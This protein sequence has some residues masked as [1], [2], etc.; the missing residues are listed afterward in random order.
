MRR[1]PA[2]PRAKRA[3]LP[4]PEP[5][6][7]RLCLT[8]HFQF[9]YS[10]D[11]LG[12]FD[13]PARRESLERAGDTLTSLLADSLSP[14][15][16]GG[17]N[18]W[19]ADFDDPATGLPTTAVNLSIP[20][21]T[22]L[23]YA[24]GR[25][26]DGSTLGIGATGGFSSF[27]TVAWNNTVKG[28]GHDAALTS[29][30]TDFVTW[31]GAITF[32]LPSDWYFGADAAGLGSTQNDF[33]SVALHE[34][35][36][37][38]GFGTSTVWS[39]LVSGGVFTGAHATAVY[40]A[41]NPPVTDGH[42]AQGLMDDGS[43]VV[44]DPVIL[45]GTRKLP[46]RLD[47]AAIQDLGWTL[48]ADPDGALGGAAVVAPPAGGT[49]GIENQRIANP[50]DV[51]LYQFQA[52]MGQTIVAQTAQLPGGTPVDTAVRLFDASGTELAI[53]DDPGDDTL[54]FTAPA[55]GTYVIGVSSATNRAYSVKE[56]PSLLL[57]GASGDYR[58]LLSIADPGQTPTPSP[59]APPSAAPV[60]PPAPAPSPAPTPTPT[61]T[62][63]PLPF[64]VPT[65]M[66]EAPPF[67]TSV[68]KTMIRIRSAPKA[69]AS[70]SPAIVVRFSGDLDPTTAGLIGSYQVFAGRK[71]RGKGLVFDRPVKLASAQYNADSRSATIM[72]ARGMT[73]TGP[74]QLV[75]RSQANLQSPE[76]TSLDGDLDGRAGGSFVARIG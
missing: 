64:P 8:I 68:E 66:P 72:T 63:A 6:E 9:D 34:L 30:P 75:I 21:D 2:L 50:T 52:A 18:T 42:W 10:R 54:T 45:Q 32:D 60:S 16:P 44:M 26:L 13:D 76:G 36:H 3:Y 25:D 71:V 58:L 20:A 69:R 15:N 35:T 27:G 38:L 56:S 28:R 70:R 19:T 65:T 51:N 1:I 73:L 5:L 33:T 67:V 59:A 62:P 47:Y 61:P 43:E 74:L 22:L 29:P 14:I 31:G 57:A 17:L 53:A 4:V 41:G 40:G 39:D 37:L 48:R 23:V 55:T 12:F 11:V 46:T 24:G 49:L 7:H